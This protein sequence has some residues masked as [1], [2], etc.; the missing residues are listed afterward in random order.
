MNSPPVAIAVSETDLEQWRRDGV[1]LI[2]NAFTSAELQPLL[3]DYA[4]LHPVPNEP[5]EASF[6]ADLGE[7]VGRFSR[8]QFK[9]FLNYPFD[10]CLATNLFALH[11][12]LIEIARRCLGVRDV[13]MYQCHTWAKFTGE[14][15]YAQEFHYDFGNHSLLVPGDEP[16]Y[17]TVNYVIYLTDVSAANGAM[18]Y[19]PR[20]LS[21]TICP[22]DTPN[23]PAEAQGQLRRL[24]Q[25]AEGPA[26]SLL[27]YDTHVY[28][29]GTNLIARGAHR[30]TMTV[31]YR[32][33]AF[34]ANGGNEWSRDGQNP[35]WVGILTGASVEQL[36][37]LGIPRPGHAYWTERTIERVQ[38]RYPEWDLQPWRRALRSN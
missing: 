22:D 1:V 37:A 10:A 4:R 5:A 24:E 16:R 28:H 6:F 17:G 3:D 33:L 19:V 12:R 20:S 36:A 35:P 15:D 21:R 18:A 23:P 38:R 8:S 34:D 29:R 11:P 25:L 2:K 9:N 7:R 14:T 30:Y 31:S 27:V 26:G 32:A 13:F